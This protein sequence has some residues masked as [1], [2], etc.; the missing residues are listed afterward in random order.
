M[1]IKGKEELYLTDCVEGSTNIEGV[2]YFIDKDGHIYFALSE[3]EEEQK[4]L[5]ERYSTAMLC[6]IGKGV[7]VEPYPGVELNYI[8]FRD[9]KEFLESNLHWFNEELGEWIEFCKSDKTEDDIS[10]KEVI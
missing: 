7:V 5:A 2:K 10:Y 9:D 3:T 4:K 8:P 1:E 6:Y